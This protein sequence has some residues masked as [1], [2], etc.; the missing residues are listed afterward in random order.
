V[1]KAELEMF[2]KP[3]TNALSSPPQLIIRKKNIGSLDK[4]IIDD[5]LYASNISSTLS[6]FGGKPEAVTINGV[7]LLRYKFNLSAYAQKMI[8]DSSISDT[9]YVTFE[10]KSSS[11]G[12]T[13]FYGAKHSKYPMK[14]RIYCTKI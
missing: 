5:V 9:F 11:I 10:N 7:T 13:V 2:V 3:T 6:P 12:R 14:F 4:D 1:N 8:D